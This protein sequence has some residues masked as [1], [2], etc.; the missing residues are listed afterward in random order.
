MRVNPTIRKLLMPKNIKAM[1]LKKFNNSRK[2]F[3]ILKWKMILKP[4]TQTIGKKLE[5]TLEI[6]TLRI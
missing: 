3:R 4:S 6:L 5:K 2:R 1:K